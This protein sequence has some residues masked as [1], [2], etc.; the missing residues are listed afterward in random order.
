M[1]EEGC[2]LTAVGGRERE[3]RRWRQRRR[4]PQRGRARRLGGSGGAGEAGRLGGRRRRGGAERSAERRR[5]GGGARR[6]RPDG[7]EGCARRGAGAPGRPGG[8]R[9]LR[10][11]LGA[12]SPGSLGSPGA[13]SSALHWPLE[14]HCRRVRALRPDGPPL[15]APRSAFC[16]T[17]RV[18]TRSPRL[19][20]GHTATHLLRRVRRPRTERTSGAV[21]L[22]IP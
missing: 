19:T 3:R 22:C 2:A 17:A 15:P 13:P 12:S 18:F 1:Q 11:V 8:G 7:R 4:C 21:M 20:Q 16:E 6:D 10:W 9:R 5:A 14:P